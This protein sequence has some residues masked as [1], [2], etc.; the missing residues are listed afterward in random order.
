MSEF[1]KFSSK[2]SEVNNSMTRSL[3]GFDLNYFNEYKIRDLYGETSKILTNLNIEIL[4]FIK[5]SE[6]KIK[7]LKIQK[8]CLLNGWHKHQINCRS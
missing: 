4:D 6:E 7:A 8:I 3:S 5:S 1:D 2:Y